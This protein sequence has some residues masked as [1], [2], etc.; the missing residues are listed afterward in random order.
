MKHLPNPRYTKLL[1]EI[2]NVVLEMYGG[3]IAQSS[4]L[5]DL[6]RKISDKV[7]EE[8]RLE[9]DLQEIMG[10]FELISSHAA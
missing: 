3:V 5:E 8:L 9:H 2:V 4:L 1:V 10:I 6:M 7:Q